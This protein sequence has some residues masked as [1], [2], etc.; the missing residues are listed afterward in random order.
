MLK[1]PLIYSG[2]G[3]SSTTVV[4]N[5]L[6]S[7]DK[8]EILIGLCEGPIEGLENGEKSFY[9]DD[10]PL[11]ASDDSYNFTDYTLD[12]KKGDV[13][14]D[15]TIQFQLGGSGRQTSVGIELQKDQ[16]ITRVTQSGNINYIDVRVTVNQ[17][18]YQDDDGNVENGTIQFKIEYK[19]QDQANWNSYREN[20]RE[21][22]FISGKTTSG[23]AKDY[24]IP[25]SSSNTYY[26]EIRLTKL[27]DNSPGDG[28]GLNNK[29]TWTY[30]EEVTAGTGSYPNTALA[31]LVVKTTDQLT[32]IPKMSGV[33]KF[34]K[35]KVPSNYNP[36]TR[37]YVGDWDGTFQVAWTDNPAWC[38]YD[39]IMNDRYGVNAYYPVTADKWDFYEAA[40]Y[41]DELVP[42]GVGGT[43]PRYTMNLVIEE[44]QTGPEMIN[45]LAGVFNATIY[46]DGTGTVRL[47]FQ[48]DQQATHVFSSE[49]VTPSGFV[50]N[51]S[52]PS[53][54]Y[55]DVSVSF[56]NESQG[57]ISDTR[58][59]YDSQN[60]SL[61]GRIVEEYTAVGCIKESEALRRARYRL[62]T[63]L[64]ETMSVTF[65][66]C[67]AGCNINLFDTILVADENMGY[68]LTGRFKSLSAD[69]LHATLRDDI[70]I[71][72]GVPYSVI[73]QGVD[74][75]ITVNLNV[76]EVGYVKDLYFTDALDVSVIPEKTVFSLVGGGNTGSPKPFRVTAISESRGDE[77]GIVI[78]AVEVNRNKQ[79]EADNGIQLQA[80]TYS[81]LPSYLIIPHITG[82][83]LS[84]KYIPSEKAI[85][86]ILE[87]KLPTED[88]PYYTN[89]FLAYSRKVGDTAWTE[90][91]IKFGDTIVDHPNGTY[92]F[93]V[94]PKT[95]LGKTP[96]FETAPIF[97]FT[98][99]DIT[100]P[101]KDVT[102]FTA[103]PNINNIQFEWNE[104]DDP[105]LIGYEIRMGETWED[106]TVIASYLVDNQF[107][108]T[109][110]VTTNTKFWIKAID[111]LDNYS[112]NP[113]GV[114]SKLSV[115]LGPTSFFVT[116]N[117]DTLRFDW[118]APAQNAVEFEVRIGESWDSGLKLFKT[119][120]FNNTILN[121]TPTDA[122]YMIRAVSKSGI[123][124][125]TYR[126]A[127][128]RVQLQQNR[129][130]ILQ[131]D[132]ADDNWS[133][134]TTG[135][136][137]TQFND[138]LAMKEGAFYGEH[139]F[140]VH[141]DELTYARNWYETEGFKYGTRLTFDD[142]NYTWG[143]DEA[144]T[145]NWLSSTGLI[146]TEG[147]IQ[148][149]ITYALATNSYAHTF[150]FRFD[151]TLK[152]VT[153]TINATSSLDLSYGDAR[154]SKGLNVHRNSKVSYES[155]VSIGPQFSL[156]FK[157]KINQY[158]GY[159][160]PI[161]RLAGTG[162]S[163]YAVISGQNTITITR[164]DG[165]SLTDTYSF[166]ADA[167]YIYFMITQ[168]ATKLKLDY[169]VEY[170]NISGSK[171]V[172][173]SPLGTFNKLY[174]GGK[175]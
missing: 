39:L 92:E 15:E 171:E 78:T 48:K 61:W 173:C 13:V 95:T 146:S 53:T 6:F 55:N 148:P 112:V 170:A 118:T 113:V 126:Y 143:S 50:Y 94:L 56:M 172:D 60:V 52:D 102:T 73:L 90:R 139:Y 103:T 41:C 108:Y 85:Y 16:P 97:T 87:P 158:C 31:H 34:L 93:R 19:R 152:D 156:K 151:N 74:G 42:D 147:T 37:A 17:L 114:T 101:P 86:T 131:I 155:G 88:Y 57:W 128:I 46:E 26:Y 38:L 67:L 133:G 174:L 134:V 159:N 160:I 169:S 125:E 44:S 63:N 157:I 166:Y 32:S 51:F 10:T 105:D 162:I 120:G 29:L 77:P 8:A 59:V 109:A 127:E 24:R 1:K 7:S 100:E 22:L 136:E 49:N 2:G 36:N 117:L 5:N 33:Y 110:E 91:E 4:K 28:V 121:P 40:K 141:L 144:A 65:T 164:S 69:G 122:G 76:R 138:V 72:A 98:L 137:R 68:S 99:T 123:Y 3:G 58:R 70:F 161:M 165:V 11:K 27:N 30:F 81:K 145:Q 82:L 96:S 163:I 9:F 106:G 115:P 142:L 129:N 149:V 140:Q 116:P 89:D 79:Q 84:Q 66:T 47:A 71:E 154:Y 153:D 35:I 111:V 18:Y 62:L 135:M 54:R 64:T 132:N 20:G 45:Y 43:E 14:S 80:E 175:S 168:T 83:N 75:P 12:I 124:S 21:T 104:V 167:D 119:S 23:Y 150:G 107:T 25:V 130:V